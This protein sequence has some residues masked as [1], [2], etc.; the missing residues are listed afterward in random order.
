MTEPQQPS[1]ADDRLARA[2]GATAGGEGAPSAG[3]VKD[4]LVLAG[5]S[6]RAAGTRAVTSGRWLSEIT[7]DAAGHLPVRDL[8]TLREHHDGLAGALLARILIRNAS[9]ASGAVGAITGAFAAASESNPAGWVA[10]PV[11]LAVETLLV[12]GIEMKLV[13]ELHEA[14]G[15]ALPDELRDKGPLIAKA[16]AETRGLGP[17]DLARLARPGGQAQIASAAAG[18][19]G[20]TSRDQLAQQIRRRLLKRAGRNTL[21]FVP[22]LA[23]ALA[24]G[25]LNRRATR[26]LGTQ[27]A[28]SLR[29]PP[30]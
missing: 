9:L 19:L 24:G 8:A 13:G 2:I 14:A 17:T 18:I 26:K 12:V 27:V 7:L 1:D 30:P 6:A 23:G 29:I 20:R 25:E 3:Q 11:E 22:F 5:R 28:G 21:S 15:V 16:W 4:V 10:L